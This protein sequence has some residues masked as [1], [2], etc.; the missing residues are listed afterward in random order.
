VDLPI[1][2]EA[3]FVFGVVGVGNGDGEWIAEGGGGL[4]KADAMLAHVGGRFARVPRESES[5]S[6]S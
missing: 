6:E 5:H 1:N 2:E 3:F 4:G